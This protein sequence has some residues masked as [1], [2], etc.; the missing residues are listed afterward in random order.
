MKKNKIFN[1]IKKVNTGDTINTGDY[2]SF[3]DT[4]PIFPCYYSFI[5]DDS[6]PSPA[7]IYD[8]IVEEQV[9]DNKQRYGL[10]KVNYETNAVSEYHYITPAMVKDAL[11]KYISC[12]YKIISVNIEDSGINS[13]S[14]K[15][16]Y[17]LT[18]ELKALRT[19]NEFLENMYR[20]IKEGD[21]VCIDENYYKKNNI[22]PG[23]DINLFFG[24]IGTVKY[25]NFNSE[26]GIM[27][28]TV[29][30]I[31]KGSSK[32]ATLSFNIEALKKN[33]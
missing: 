18:N 5:L 19:R 4:G 29:E 30:I 23:M 9:I 2:Y 11:N 26:L 21:K 33:S 17:S 6:Y 15:I 27:I 22:T 16:P 10:F 7:T 25:I 20:K 24:Q 13:S 32:P 14:G 1:E 12:V 3:E 31:R 28:A 8:L